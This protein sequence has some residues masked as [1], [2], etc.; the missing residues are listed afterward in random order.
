[1]QLGKA[2]PEMIRDLPVGR[3]PLQA[4]LHLR[5]RLLE[6]PMF[7]ADGARH[8]VERTQLVDDG[9][10]NPGNGVG[11]ELDVPV[12]FELLQRIDETEHP[13]GDQVGLLHAGGQARGDTTGH[14]LDER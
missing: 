1:M 5:V 4:R 13:V 7:E 9:A 14:V 6:L 12:E 10:S 11:L 3:G 8:P 2:D